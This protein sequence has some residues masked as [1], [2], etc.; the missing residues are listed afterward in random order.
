[1]DITQLKER[2]CEISQMAYVVSLRK[3][4]T[5]IGYTLETLL[6]LKENNLK[7]PDLGE[8]EVKSQRK[9]VS[10]RLTMFT[11]NRGVW[12]IKQKELIERYG[13]IDTNGRPSLYCTVKSSPNN[14]GLCVKV[15]QETVRLYHV[16]GLLIAEWTGGNLINSFMK[17]MPSLVIVYADTRINSDEKEE[18]WFNEAFYL[19]QPNEDNLLDL[20]K[21]DIIIVDVRM[22]LKENKA[23]RNH[24][25]GFRID[26]KFLSLCFGSREK[27]I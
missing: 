22:H 9:D 27:L 13:Y 11:F 23:V 2:L 20:I 16:D 4:N 1:M 26:E 24:G 3:G 6:G 15:E 12:K 10:N 8:I 7:M 17:K 14:Q 5:G 21:K 18:F 25:T 19:T